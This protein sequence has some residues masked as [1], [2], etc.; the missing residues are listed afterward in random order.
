[1]RAARCSGSSGGDT[2][3]NASPTD[4]RS[5]TPPA[6]RRV[7]SV[8]RAHHTYDPCLDTLSGDSGRG[9]CSLL[10]AGHPSEPENSHYFFFLCDIVAALCAIR[11]GVT[12]SWRVCPEPP[13]TLR[14]RSPDRHDQRPHAPARLTRAGICAGP[15]IEANHGS[16]PGRVRKYPAERSSVQGISLHRLPSERAMRRRE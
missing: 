15:G 5:T 14:N 8:P 16:S 3:T 9:E 11:I 10:A 13:A 12:R 7:L 2:R 6:R 4:G 1:M